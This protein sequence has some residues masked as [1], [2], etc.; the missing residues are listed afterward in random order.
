MKKKIKN[1]L[2]RKKPFIIAEVSGNHGGSLKKMLKIVEA[3]ADTGA[4]AIKLQTFKPDS[5]TLNS[6]SKEFLISDKNSKWNKLRLYDLYKKSQTPW[7]WHKTIFKKAK[8]LGLCAFSTPFDFSAVD[9]LEKLNVPLYKI[10]SFE[11]N[12]LPLIK[13][14]AKT[15]KPIIIST[16]LASLKEI[17]EAVNS[18]KE[19]GCKELGL[20]KCT[21]SYPAKIEDSNLSSISKLKSIYDF[22]IGLSDHT[23][24][25]SAALAAVALGATIIEK[26]LTLSRKNN[27]VDS[28]FSLEPHEFKQLVE[29]SKNVWKSLGSDMFELTNAEKRTKIFR[30]SIYI[31]KNLKAGEI[32]NETN[33]KIIRPNFG[34][35]PREFKNIL[36]KKIVKDAS[37]GTPLSKDLLNNK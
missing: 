31:S 13:S 21:S 3:I 35:H 10:A 25:I 15:G 33:V 19:S 7:D 34:L 14:V 8:Q 26:H 27:S 17:D 18:A 22:E 37:K 11:N 6:N 16:G 12:H 32:L 1:F 2:D 23:L 5:I 28:S 24:G 20:L 29:E 36:G 4:D 9:F 30:R